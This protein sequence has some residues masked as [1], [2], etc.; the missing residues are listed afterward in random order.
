[1]F[2]S[3]KEPQS[4]NFLEPVYSPTDIWS[5]AYIWL[6]DVGKYLLIGVELIVLGVFFS[7]FVLD[8]QNNDLTEEINGKVALLSNE[9]WKQKD[10]LFGNY[11]T[12]FT[13]IK[14]IQ[15][16][17][18]I[19]SST[20]S[21]LVSGIPSLLTLDSFSFTENRVFL[22]F[23]TTSFETVKNYETAL[24]NN[25][26]YKDVNFNIIKEK[27]DINVKVTFLLNAES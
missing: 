8:R 23:T 9:S 21:E 15:G 5:K 16:D 20:I 3:K 27:S 14:R 17:Q 6:A 22:G 10:V 24:K 2:K 4:I 19:N 11:Q 13:D 7:R 18:S 26:D 1:M 25:P 12:L